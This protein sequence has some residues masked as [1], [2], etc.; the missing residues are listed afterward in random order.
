VLK[1]FLFIALTV[2]ISSAVGRTWFFIILCAS[3][4]FPLIIHLWWLPKQGV[5]GWT[6]EP[7]ERYYELRGWK[8][9]SG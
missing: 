5:N 4:L 3:L 6:A 2:L 8:L 1:F 7:K 9:P